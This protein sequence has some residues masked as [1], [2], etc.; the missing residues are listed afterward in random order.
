VEEPSL[1]DARLSHDEDDAALAT[2]SRAQPIEQE[3]KLTLP[4]DEGRS[5]RPARHV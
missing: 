4:P 2:S 3:R 5:A 1:A